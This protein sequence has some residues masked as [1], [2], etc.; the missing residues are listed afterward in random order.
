MQLRAYPIIYFTIKF[1]ICGLLLQSNGQ[2]MGSSSSA[3]NS[4]TAWQQQMMSSDMQQQADH[5]SMSGD[6]GASKPTDI[7]GLLHVQFLPHPY[8]AN[9]YYE[10][11]GLQFAERQCPADCVWNQQLAMCV[12]TGGGGGDSAA[13][14]TTT[15]TTPAAVNPCAG[16]AANGLQQVPFPGDQSRFIICYDSMRFDVYRCSAGLV[17][18]QSQQMCGSEPTTTTTTTTASPPP[19]NGS[20]M[21]SLCWSGSS[22]TSSSS[23]YHAYPPD[24]SRFLQCD[25]AGHV[26]VLRCGPAKVWDDGYKTC[27]GDNSKTA[28]MGQGNG[29]GQ[30]QGQGQG[31]K[32]QWNVMAPV[33]QQGSQGQQSQD[34]GQGQGSAWLWNMMMQQQSQSQG[35]KRQWEMMAPAQQQGGQGQQG[36]GQEQYVPWPQ[37]MMANQQ[38]QIQGGNGQWN[39]MQ[40]GQDQQGG[41][42]GQGDPWSQSMMASQQGQRAKWQWDMMATSQG[43]NGGSMSTKNA[44]EP[45]IFWIV[46]PLNHQFDGQR[47]VCAMAAGNDWAPDAGAVACPLG[48]SWIIELRV[49]I[50][51]VKTSADDNGSSS[52]SSSSGQMTTNGGNNSTSKM[53]SLSET[54]NPCVAGT[55]FYYP[56]PNNSAFFVQCD[57]TGNA[58]VQPCPAGLEWN[59]QLLTCAGAAEDGGGKNKT[60]GQNSAGKPGGASSGGMQNGA[61]GGSL[62]SQPGLSVALLAPCSLPFNDGAVFPNPADAAVFVQCSGGVPVVRPCE[63]KTVW[64]QRIFSCVPVDTSTQ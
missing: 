64:N 59:Q 63:P 30:S 35:A 25:S 56:F 22:S 15:T 42:Q 17:W 19:D 2:S 54:E 21:T 60:G 45:E 16:L 50:Q 57:P 52:S 3:G 29:Q 4:W 23:F 1:I 9:R 44:T 58:F 40:G 55:G 62:G 28:A 38:S 5:G 47:G 61:G 32:W 27:V 46:C 43:Q 34:Q 39:V 20:G 11:V 48:F 37:N 12:K 14:M 53:P 26:Y 51:P 49:C 10:C 36:Q 33:Q 41:G 13:V 6:S 24:Q 7:C 8:N 31:D 18:L